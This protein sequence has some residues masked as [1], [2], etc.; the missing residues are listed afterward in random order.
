MPN[1]VDRATSLSAT[2]VIQPTVS[3]LTV[4]TSA[5][6]SEP[7]DITSVVDADGVSHRVTVTAQADGV[8]VIEGVAD[9]LVVRIPPR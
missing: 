5:L 6:R 2:V 3:G 8:A 4:P 9:G 1:R 7:G